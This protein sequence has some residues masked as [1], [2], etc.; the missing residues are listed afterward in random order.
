M[1]RALLIMTLVAACVAQTAT[2]NCGSDFCSNDPMYSKKLS[3]KED[4]MKRLNYPADLIALMEL[5]GACVA[6]VDRA[7][8]GFRIKLMHSDGSS[9]NRLDGG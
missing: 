8:V 5:D 3:A 7:P 1:L 9:S 4:A 2:C 6:R